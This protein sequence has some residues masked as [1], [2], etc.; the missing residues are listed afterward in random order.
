M[1]VKGVVPEIHTVR[2]G[3][4]EEWLG[5]SLYLDLCGAGSQSFHD[6]PRVGALSAIALVA[7]V[8]SLGWC[9]YAAE[10]PGVDGKWAQAQR[11]A[12]HQ[13]IPDD[14]VERLLTLVPQRAGATDTP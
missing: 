2:S 9:L 6:P 14:Y 12:A 10:S 13:A 8:L 3:R 1:H 11:Q 5:A 7:F 4:A